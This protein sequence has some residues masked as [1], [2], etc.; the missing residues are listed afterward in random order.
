MAD[1]HRRKR[2]QLTALLTRPA[3]YATCGRDVQNSGLDVLR[4]LCALDGAEW[5]DWVGPF[6]HRFGKLGI[7]GAFH[8]TFD[9]GDEIPVA[10]ASVSA[11][12]ASEATFDLSGVGP[13]ANDTYEVRLVGDGAAP[14]RDTDD[15]ALDGEFAGS[16]PSG[17]GEAGG[18]LVATFTVFT[19][20]TTSVR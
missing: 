3:I 8:G 9:D 15:R 19:P 17:D 20:P 2:E 11:T 5:P 16:F 6:L 14:M 12:G 1:F 7:D 18:D 10:A 4:D 13:L